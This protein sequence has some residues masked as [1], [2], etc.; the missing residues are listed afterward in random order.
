MTAIFRQIEDI[1]VGQPG[2]L[3]GELVAFARGGADRHGKAIVDDPGDFAF[4]PADMVEIGNHAVADIA[5]AG[6]EQSQSA[7]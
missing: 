7:R 2:E 6:G 5:D 4:D 3:G 1:A